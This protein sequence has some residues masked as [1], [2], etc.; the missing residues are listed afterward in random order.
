[1]FTGS[2]QL[3]MASRFAG[4]VS[5]LLARLAQ[6]DAAKLGAGFGKLHM[7]GPG[8]DPL[9]LGAFMF[10]LTPSSWPIAKLCLG[11]FPPSFFLHLPPAKAVVL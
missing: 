10:V 8:R 5:L 11:V 1:M 9:S 2:E 6:K 3:T 4:L 7:A